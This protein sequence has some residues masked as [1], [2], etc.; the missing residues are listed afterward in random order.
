MPPVR[1]TA[2]ARAERLADR[3]GLPAS[4]P[5]PQAV[6]DACTA[7]LGAAQ[8][9]SSS[10]DGGVARDYSLL[11][12]WSSSYPETTGYIIPTMIAVARRTGDAALHERARRML[13]WCVAI[14]FPAG[15]FQ[16]GK[17][18][19]TPR[20]P[21]TFNTGQILLGLAAGVAAYG[22]AYEDALHRAARWLR[23]SQDADGC[24]RRHPTPFAR[25]G[26]KAYET[27][28]AW[29]LFE[30]DRAAPGHGYGA[31]G[32]RQ[33]DWA[34]TRQQP[35]GWFASNCLD[36]PL[37]PLSHTI[38]YVLRGLLEAQRFSARADLLDAAVRTGTGVANAVADDGYLPG[39]L[40]H[41]FLPGADFACLTGSAQNAHCLFLLYQ[42]TGERRFLDAAR[43]L[44]GFVRR[45]VAIDG[46]AHVRGGVKGA[47]P[48]DGDY[49]AWAY[50]NWAAKFCIDA[51][52]LELE[53][54][55]A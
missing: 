25:P 24:W 39:R 15:G 48:V 1:L 45:T 46:P 54:G 51:N 14:Q 26:D 17:I 30:A 49:G 41:A 29:G 21:V 36:E 6:I 31:A 19:S 38:G 23:D 18:D 13:D 7:W 2:A 42:R 28:V 20:V 4:D 47:F 22:A 55:D 12:G 9:H 40:D 43:R 34:L 8:D 35:N 37:K 33:V 3:R 5:G 52:L 10:N 32:L 11:T 16:G 44:N 27:H 50:L 53:V